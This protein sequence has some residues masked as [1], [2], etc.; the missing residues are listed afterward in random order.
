MRKFFINKQM[1]MRKSVTTMMTFLLLLCAAAAF[2]Q[3]GTVT[4]TVT[5]TDGEPLIGVNVSVR[6]TTIGAIT[7][8][9][10]NYSLQGVPAQATL[11][12][13]YIGFTSQEVPVANQR[14]INVQLREDTQRLDEVVVVGYSTQQKKDITGSVAV[15]DTK[16]MLKSTGSSAMAQLQGK[17]SGIQISSSS[18]AGGNTMVRIR[19]VGSVNTNNPLFVI[20]GISSRNQNLNS[21]NPNDIESLQVLKDASASAIYGA[22]AANGVILITTKKGVNTGQPIVTYDAYYGW[23]KPGKKYDLLNAKDR[24]DLEYLGMLN[25]SK[26][27]GTYKSDDPSTWP[28]HELFKTSATG[29]TPY[30]YQSNTQGGIDSYNMADY[31]FVYPGLQVFTQYSD[32]DWWKEISRDTAP[33]QNHQFGLRGGNDK[34]QYSAS[35]NIF[36]QKSTLEYAYYKRFSTRLNTSFNIR[37]WLRIGE[38]FA[39]SWWRDLGVNN[40]ATEGT[41]YSQAYRATPWVPVYDVGGNFSGSI[42]P[43][44]GNWNNPVA[45]MARQEDNYWTNNRMN[46]SVWGEVDLY[47]GLTFTSRYGIEYTNQWYYR[48]DKINLEFSESP[49]TNNLQE[50]SSFNIR[51]VWNNTLT[52][53]AVFNNIHR[54]TALIG[55]EAITDGFGRTLTGQRYNYMFENNVNTWTLDM[56]DRNDQREANSSYNGEYALFGIFGRVDYTFSDK[57][58]FTGTLRRDGSSR[59]SQSNRYGT[60]PSV[61]LGWRVSQEDFMASTRDWLD[62]LKFRVGYGQVGNIEGPSATNWA[63]TFAMSASDANYPVNGSNQGATAFRQSRIG[64]EDTKWEAIESLNVGVDASLLNGKFGLGFE[65]YNRTTTNMLIQA[66]YSNLAGEATAPYI[67]YGSMNNK[68]FDATLN[69]YDNK[70]DWSWN[71]TL[72]LSHYKNQV[73]SLAQ[74]PGYT[75]WGGGDRIVNSGQ[76]TRTTEGAPISQF[77]GYRVDGIYENVAQVQ[78]RVPRGASTTMTDEQAQVYV[79][80]FKFADL[81]GDGRLTDTDD[82][83]VIGDPH[84]DLIAGLNLGVNYKNFD[85]TMFWYSTIGNDIFNNTLL[86]TDFQQFRGNRSSRMRDNSWEPGRTVDRWTLPQLNAADGYSTIVC[87]YF[88]EDGSFLRLNNLVLGY[89]FPKQILQKAT[90]SNLRVYAQVENALT[91]TKYTGLDPQL[92]L[93]DN[94]SDNGRDRSRGIDGGGNPNVVRFILGVNF[95][96]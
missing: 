15:V 90:I 18:S 42:I 83:E 62:D 48:M 94:D 91:F 78:Q 81:D 31:N 5:D 29:F 11:V 28:S 53:S 75:L 38:D 89:T 7:N 32:T 20:D 46:L 69:Y 70:G 85:L 72:T 12:F 44:T 26:N 27:N 77:W 49:R 51:T 39:Y 93:R 16:E 52:Y 60:F 68:G 76:I 34:G 10:G 2:A 23:Q 17:V 95:A 54:L 55:T 13:S 66:A 3:T 80:Y 33:V 35:I 6:G 50:R 57:Y 56:G 73:V 41:M 86:W 40:S 82:R 63:S 88:V 67:N 1:K 84:P 96:F 19:G 25:R 37:P 92:T 59:L 8:I 36:D 21:I 45:Q 74:N 64:N 24:M 9:D 4:G 87:S 22:Q 30:P 71:A 43:G 61:S 65:W 47:K 58:L 14:T 79:G